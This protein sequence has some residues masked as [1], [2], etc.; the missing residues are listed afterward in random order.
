MASLLHRKLDSHVWRIVIVYTGMLTTNRSIKFS[1]ISQ[2]PFVKGETTVSMAC[3]FFIDQKLLIFQQN[4]TFP[5]L[6]TTFTISILSTVL[7]WLI[8]H[9]KILKA[10][11]P[12]SCKLAYASYKILKRICEY[13]SNNKVI[14]PILVWGPKI[15]HDY[16]E[17]VQLL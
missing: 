1:D 9:P 15:H 17:V 16:E 12:T 3:F 14:P 6:T 5:E 13:W 4:T 8:C 7:T 2:N 10:R 11:T